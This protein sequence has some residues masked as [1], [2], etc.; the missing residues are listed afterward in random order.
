M[1]ANFFISQRAGTNRFS[2]RSVVCITCGS[3]ISDDVTSLLHQFI[4][5][6]SHIQHPRDIGSFST[7]ATNTIQSEPSPL[8]LAAMLTL[9][10]LRKC[11]I[12]VD[13]AG[14]IEPTGTEADGGWFEVNDLRQGHI[15]IK[16][17]VR[18]IDN[19]IIRKICPTDEITTKLN[20]VIDQIDRATPLPYAEL[21]ISA[22]EKRDLPWKL[23]DIPAVAT[24]QLGI[25]AQSKWFHQSFSENESHFSY[26]L[27]QNKITSAELLRNYGI[28]APENRVCNSIDGAIQ[29]ADALGYPVVIKPL[30]EGGS[31]G[32]TVDIRDKKTL[33][34]AFKVAAEFNGI[35]IVESFVKGSNY[36]ILTIDGK[37]ISCTHRIPPTIIGD[38]RN[39]IRDLCL[40][41]N[42]NPNRGFET[43][44]S[45]DPIPIDILENQLTSPYK[46]KG[47]D[48][49]TVP[50]AGEVVELTY[51]PGLSLGSSFNNATHLVNHDVIRM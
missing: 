47:Y 51:A 23:S 5:A 10:L 36:R 35:A 32:I 3:R 49:N 20:A 44:F 15:A 14:A 19:P 6:T 24:F 45:R 31:R 1:A 25:G 18:M 40:V 8:T 4:E 48:L 27:T 38:G 30:R 13:R 37:F 43:R 11:G 28:P 26:R 39:N 22:A 46:S 9:I 12:R 29:A 21:I 34:E 2:R 42:T 17:V 50:G 33:V 16:A 41:E 7:L